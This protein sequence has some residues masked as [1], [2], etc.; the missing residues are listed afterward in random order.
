MST[1]NLILKVIPSENWATSRVKIVWYSLSFVNRIIVVVCTAYTLSSIVV[2]YRIP[3]LE[4]LISLIDLV[5]CRSRI[6]II[7]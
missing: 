4:V 2:H 5:S 7:H 6:I 1:L 3:M